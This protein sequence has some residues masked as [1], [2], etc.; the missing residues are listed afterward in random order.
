MEL[1]SWTVA[2][3]LVALVLLDI[4]L[5]AWALWP[6]P[7]TSPTQPTTVAVT[8]TGPSTADSASATAAPTP[9]VSADSLAPL[10][11]F[12]AAV[13]PTTAWLVDG[14]ECGQP[15]RLHV[16]LDGG[17][18]WATE[19]AQG[20]ITRL[21][22]S[23][24]SAAFVVG[25]DADCTD[26]VWYTRD[27]GASWS[28]PQE[29]SNAWGRSSK[30]SRLV[31]RPGGEPVRPCE[32]AEVLDL[33]G[34]SSRDGAVLCS[35]GAIRVTSDSGDSWTMATSRQGLLA[36]SLTSGGE[37][38]AVGMADDC[39][40]LAVFEVGSGGITESACVERASHIPGQ[41]AISVAEGAVWLVA[42]DGI[43]RAP[44]L[45]APFERV[46]TWPGPE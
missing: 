46:S 16:T 44:D 1:R 21:R 26:R 20:S 17:A 39:Q 11:R 22:P 29:A 43:Y 42:G 8:P 30:D 32:V 14:G 45:Q 9:P 15:G 37:G 5:V 41:V 24:A 25:G 12:V 34:L 27:R 19:S 38:A 36:I 2:V 35:D 33:V 23:D 18:E 10:V 6:S 28:S 4:G 31:L 13:D 3:G 7:A 40:G